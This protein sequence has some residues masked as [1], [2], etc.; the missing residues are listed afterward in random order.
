MKVKAVI[1]SFPDFVEVVSLV[2]AK[3]LG[4]YRRRCR[5]G[6]HEVLYE[7]LPFVQVFCMF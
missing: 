4:H 1:V 7:R 6:G 3:A 2:Q 5:T